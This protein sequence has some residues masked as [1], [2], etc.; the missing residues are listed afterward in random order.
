MASQ[1]LAIEFGPGPKTRT[2]PPAIS[3]VPSQTAAKTHAKSRR[4]VRSCVAA[5]WLFGATSA[6]GLAHVF[7]LYDVVPSVFWLPLAI[8][9]LGVAGSTYWNL[10][11]R[12]LA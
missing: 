10:R 3:V 1:V 8:G 6:L 2:S 12:W 5:T 9:S 11:R 4:L 7:S